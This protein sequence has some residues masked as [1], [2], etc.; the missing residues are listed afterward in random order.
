MTPFVVSSSFCVRSNA[1]R[2]LIYARRYSAEMEVDPG[3]ILR[4][5][6]VLGSADPLL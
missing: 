1:F 6:V 5:V 2:I 3:F 4:Y